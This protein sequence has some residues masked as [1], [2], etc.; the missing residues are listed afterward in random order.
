ML[1]MSISCLSGFHWVCI[2]WLV[3]YFRLNGRTNSWFLLLLK[4]QPWELLSHSVSILNI[5]ISEMNLIRSNPPTPIPPSVNRLPLIANTIAFSS[6]KQ[7]FSRTYVFLI[8]PLFR[9]I[10]KAVV[11]GVPMDIVCSVVK[12]C[13]YCYYKG[14]FP[15]LAVLHCNQSVTQ[16][17]IVTSL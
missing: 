14:E 12:D 16:Y 8:P 11:L 10:L 5:I 4:S 13:T 17:C 3:S 2:L 15:A 6:P 7:A 9:Q 1:H